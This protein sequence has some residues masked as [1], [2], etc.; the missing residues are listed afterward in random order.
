MIEISLFGVLV[1]TLRSAVLLVLVLV[2]LTSVTYLSMTLITAIRAIPGPRP[3]SPAAQ[4]R[5]RLLGLSAAIAG[6]GLALAGLRVGSA[7]STGEFIPTL[8]VIITGAAALGSATACALLGAARGVL[9]LEASRAARAWAIEQRAATTAKRL[10]AE[11]RRRL[12]GDDLRDEEAEAYAALERLRGALTQLADTHAE[13]HDKLTRSD[14]ESEIAAEYRRTEDA[15]ATKLEL[16]ERVLGAAEAA[17]FRLACNGPLRR[18]SRRRPREAL[19]GLERLEQ[20]SGR[21]AEAVSDAALDRARTAIAAFLGEIREARRAL[22]AVGERRPVSMGSPGGGPGSVNPTSDEDP[23][24]L[25][26]ADLDALE[27]AFT[28]VLS[29]V[30]MI[31]VRRSAEATFSKV[32]VAASAVST[33]GKGIGADQAEIEALA[34]EVARAEAA[35]VMATPIESDAGS[36][37]VALSRCAAA[38]DLRSSASLDE[39]LKALRAI[40]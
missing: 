37:A 38:L 9:H 16:G 12:E 2:A 31:R 15:V 25:A 14:P 23:F 5:A 24:A 11:N 19:L 10:A 39:L 13:I 17:A 20:A 26:Q 18:L 21:E 28:A 4:R 27:E 1:G 30:E 40:A 8:A 6:A 7:G 29:R 36:I 3:L 34:M 33:S 32:A 35:V 22:V